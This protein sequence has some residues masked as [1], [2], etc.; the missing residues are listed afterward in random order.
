MSDNLKKFLPTLEVVSTIRDKKL[1]K[2]VLKYFA[3]NKNFAS[4]LRE[5]TKNIIKGNVQ[6]DKYKKRKIS[7][8]KTNLYSI[9]FSK[10]HSKN[11]AQ[12]GGWMWIIP[13]IASLLK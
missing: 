2:N 7:R 1:Q 10:N 12:S 4:A 5:I 13:I 3:K 8:H 6:L 9:A 11:I